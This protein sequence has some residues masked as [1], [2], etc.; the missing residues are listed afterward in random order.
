LN[1]ASGQTQDK[2]VKHLIFFDGESTC[3]IQ[4]GTA[5]GC[6]WPFRGVTHAEEKENALTSYSL[7]L[8]LIVTCASRKT[9][10]GNY[11]LKNINIYNI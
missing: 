7:R 10:A 3:I 4:S 5:C 8:F 11:I 1:E 2:K 9:T 6:C